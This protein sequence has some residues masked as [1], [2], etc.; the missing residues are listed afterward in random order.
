MANLRH[1]DNQ[2]DDIQHNGLNRDTLQNIIYCY[3]ECYCTWWNLTNWFYKVKV[4]I[5]FKDVTETLVVNFVN[6]NY[7]R[8]EIRFTSLCMLLCSYIHAPPVQCNQTMDIAGNTKGGSITVL[9]TSCLTGL[10]SAVWQ[11]TILVFI[12]K[13]G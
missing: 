5:S 13:T 2:Y 10:E 11:L 8:I 4:T 1:Y 6:I 9:L 12:C 3:A 7:S